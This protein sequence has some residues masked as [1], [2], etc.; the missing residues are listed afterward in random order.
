MAFREFDSAHLARFNSATSSEF[1]SAYESFVDAQILKQNAEPAHK[2]IAPSSF[3]CDRRSW[4]RLRGTIPDVAP[5]ADY[6]LEWAAQM[7]TA[8][9][10]VIQSNL[11]AMLGPNW[12]S[13]SDYLRNHATTLNWK[14]TLTPAEDSSETFVEIQD[15]PIRFACD[16]IV[17]WA[18]K[19][20]LL[21]IKS[22]DH[23]SWND[24]TDPKDEHAD[25]VRC[26]ATYLGLDGVLFMYVDRQYGRIK[27]YEVAIHK[28]EKQD[29]L[30]RVDRIIQY[31]DA[32]LAPAGLP[33][34]DKWCSPS[35]C[36]YYKKC[37]E[38]GR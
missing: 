16:G 29:I 31:V 27:C 32:N 37:N 7:G 6:E 26:Y 3:R 4:F 10:R 30:R 8:C 20:W 25:Q 5:T 13:V 19:F 38:Y 1:L 18:G 12:I 11:I 35:Y 36:P 22:L 14:Y 21:E 15:P 2:A 17:F 28:Y 33:K 23:G 9:H 34:G 24:L